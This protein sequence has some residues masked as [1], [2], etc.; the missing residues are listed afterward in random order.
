MTGAPIGPAQVNASSLV[1]S[2]SVSIYIY[3]FPFKITDL[4]FLFFKGCSD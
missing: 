1:F 2:V 3:I 4:N